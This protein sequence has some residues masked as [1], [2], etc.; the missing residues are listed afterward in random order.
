MLN[1]NL[2]NEKYPNV[3][4]LLFKYNNQYSTNNTQENMVEKGKVFN[5][6]LN[7]TIHVFLVE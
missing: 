1:K 3:G 7:D 2:R 4:P 5:E 6:I